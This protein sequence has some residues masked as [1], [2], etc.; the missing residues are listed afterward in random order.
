MNADASVLNRIFRGTIGCVLTVANT[1]GCGF[2]EKVYENALAHELRRA[3]LAVRQQAGVTVRYDGIAVGQYLTDFLIE[4]EVTVSN[5]SWFVR[6]TT[7]IV[8]SA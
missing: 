1:F 5:R 4:Q 7:Y 3:G 2:L 6:W 8:R